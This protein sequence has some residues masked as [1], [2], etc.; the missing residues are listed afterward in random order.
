MSVSPEEIV[1]KKEPSTIFLIT[2][3]KQKSE[4]TL[5]F[6]SIYGIACIGPAEW[7]MVV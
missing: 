5:P 3:L 4:L 7:S 6:D 2:D 1:Q